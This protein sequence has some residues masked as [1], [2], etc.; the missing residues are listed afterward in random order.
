MIKLNCKGFMMAE[1]II[2]STVIL[3]TLV[4]LYTIFNKMYIVYTE[5]SYYYN[6]DAVYAGESIYKYLVSSDKF[7]SILKKDQIK[8]SEDKIAS[9]NVNLIK[10]DNNNYQCNS[11][12]FIDTTD[13]N[14]CNGLSTTYKIKNA[15]IFPYNST[16]VN[17]DNSNVSGFDVRFKDYLDYLNT[18]LNFTEKDENDEEKQ[19]FNYIIIVELENGDYQ[20]FG[21]YRIR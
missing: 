13:T 7:V 4:G 15:T 3:G 10:K 11:D 18:S 12:F 8:Q 2:V 17:K 19:K 14:I 16:A 1:V 5:R 20:Y 9:G 6:V 21:Y